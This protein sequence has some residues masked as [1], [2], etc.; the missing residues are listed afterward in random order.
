VIFLVFFDRFIYLSFLKVFYG[1]RKCP[2][3]FGAPV[4]FLFRNMLGLDIYLLVS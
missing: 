3:A 2:S 1:L 4:G